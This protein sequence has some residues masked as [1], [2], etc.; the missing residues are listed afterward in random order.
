[1]VLCIALSGIPAMAVP[2]ESN[3]SEILTKESTVGIVPFADVIVN[4]YRKNNGQLQKRRWNETKG[5][6][7]DPQWIN[8]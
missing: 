1:M 3:A 4:K 8:C 7:V 2:I 6:W 5:C